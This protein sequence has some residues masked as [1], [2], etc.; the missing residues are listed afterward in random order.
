MTDFKGLIGI[1]Y[2]EKTLLLNLE[3]MRKVSMNCFDG[4]PLKI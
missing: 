1:F 4:E 3:L 2:T